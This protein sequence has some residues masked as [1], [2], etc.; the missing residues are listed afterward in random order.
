MA[1]VNEKTGMPQIGDDNFKGPKENTLRSKPSPEQEAKIEQ[2]LREMDEASG[3]SAAE[4]IERP[5]SREDIA[6]EYEEGLS[7]VGLT[8]EEARGIIENIVVNGFY[9]D[10]TRIGPLTF[11]YRTRNH[12]DTLRTY[13][14]VESSGIAM[15]EAMQ[16]FINRHN[17]AGSL[18]SWGDR[19]FEHPE[20]AEDREEAFK[21][22]FDFLSSISDVVSIKMM[23]IIHDFDKKIAAV[24]AD[25]SPQDF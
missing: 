3:K 24:M 18:V 8:L 17:A 19:K 11:R 21:E 16:E 23:Q 22:R 12:T 6:R 10:S 20:R 7:E 25:G 4:K 5:K 9:E 14:E 15:P 13:R 1:G 2:T